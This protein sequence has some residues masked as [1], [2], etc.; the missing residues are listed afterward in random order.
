MAA[1]QSRADAVRGVDAGAIA[2]ACAGDPARIKDS[3]RQARLE[4]L[5]Q[6]QA[7]GGRPALPPLQLAQPVAAREPGQRLGHASAHGQHLEELAH[8]GFRQKLLNRLHSL[9]GLLRVCRVQ[10]GQQVHQAGVHEEAGLRR[11]A[12]HLQAGFQRRVGHGGEIHVRDGT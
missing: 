11:V 3:V 5:E 6:L 7:G 9:R 1:W 8:L 12:Q 2:R 10:L 4:R